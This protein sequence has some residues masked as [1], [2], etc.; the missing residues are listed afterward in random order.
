MNEYMSQYRE[1]NKEKLKAYSRKY[2][3]AYRRGTKYSVRNHK[4]L[5]EESV[6][7]ALLNLREYRNQQM[8]NE[9]ILPE[10]FELIKDL[11]AIADRFHKLTTEEDFL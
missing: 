3:R 8:D 9:G 2:Y 1:K 6:K 5:F 10:L 4:G 11:S 7:D